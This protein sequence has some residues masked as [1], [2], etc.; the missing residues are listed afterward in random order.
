MG[1]AY[2]WFIRVYFRLRLTPFTLL[3]LHGT[4][5]AWPGR[6]GA[7][8]SVAPTLLSSATSN[9]TP[10][11]ACMDVV[12]TCTAQVFDAR[13]AACLRGNLAQ[14]ACCEL[15]PVRHANR[16]LSVAQLPQFAACAASK[17]QTFTV[18]VV[19]WWAAP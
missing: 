14:H 6:A 16:N 3:T 17:H 10:A 12:P 13:D 8:V 9:S 7:D 18:S 2:T 15:A 5:P 4:Q 19:A 1:S 11:D